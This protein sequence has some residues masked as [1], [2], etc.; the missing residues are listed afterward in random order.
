MQKTNEYLTGVRGIIT[1]AHQYNPEIGRYIEHFVTERWTYIA[2]LS[3]GRIEMPSEMAHDQET[4]PRSITEDRIQR[5]AASFLSDTPR[6]LEKDAPVQQPTKLNF[7]QK[8][9]RFFGFKINLE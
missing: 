6:K 9:L 4:Q 7:L 3:N 8:I 1:R 2:R 5:V